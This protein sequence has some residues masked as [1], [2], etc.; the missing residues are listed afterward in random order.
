MIYETYSVGGE[1]Y[2]ARSHK[3]IDKIKTKAGKWRYIYKNTL[4]YRKNKSIRDEYLNQRVSPYGLNEGYSKYNK[5]IIDA[6]KKSRPWDKEGTGEL[7]K[8]YN[9]DRHIL[10]RSYGREVARNAQ[11]KMNNSIQG[12]SRKKYYT[13]KAK[14][15]KALKKRKKK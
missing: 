12:I 14:V 5:N 4:D 11:E 1:L 15:E 10:D 6:W 8:S 13:V 9:E 7:T 3:Y 2:H